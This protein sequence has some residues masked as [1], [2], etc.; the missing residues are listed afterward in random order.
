M[1]EVQALFCIILSFST[2]TPLAR[3]PGCDSLDSVFL[4]RLID[5]KR[6]RLRVNR[7]AGRGDGREEDPDALTR[8]QRFAL[9]AIVNHELA[10]N[11]AT[12][13]KEIL[14]AIKKKTGGTLSSSDFNNFRRTASVKGSGVIHDYYAGVVANAD[15]YRSAPA[16]IRRA[17]TDVFGFK[18]SAAPAS[19]TLFR[20]FARI[21]DTKLEPNR[22]IAQSYKGL[23]N[24]FRYSGH[25]EGGDENKDPYMTR[26][27]MQVFPLEAEADANFT[28]FKIHYRPHGLVNKQ[29]LYV[30]E[31]SIIPLRRSTHMIFFGYEQQT[32]SPLD[33]LSDQGVRDTGNPAI[34]EFRG[35]VKRRHEWGHFMVAKVRFM[36]DS[37]QSLE[38]L[39]PKVGMFR[40]SELSATLNEEYPQ[41]DTDMLCR[42]VVNWIPNE[43]RA[44]LRL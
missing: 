7:I 3:P 41:F 27:V 5:G 4:S 16:H 40:Q 15:Y 39:L 37:R 11:S 33:I 21:A 9:M 35:I 1:Q 38:E 34:E 31:G 20:V 32:D 12:A 26:A 14:E 29:L 8:E 30:V 10:V 23:W 43:G 36:R 42:S 13:S 28:P 22:A 2:H 24:V 19:A 25:Q 18:P 6:R 17:V 44:S